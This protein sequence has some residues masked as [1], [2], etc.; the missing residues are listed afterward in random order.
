MVN[1][2]L[3]SVENRMV[4]SPFQSLNRERVRDTGLQ[5]ARA[6]LPLLRLWSAFRQER[7]AVACGR[8][9]IS[10]HRSGVSQAWT[11][12]MAAGLGMSRVSD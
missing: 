12:C 6:G 11:L 8:G 10:E 4:R 2:E 7:Y 5:L 9:D 3:H 1:D